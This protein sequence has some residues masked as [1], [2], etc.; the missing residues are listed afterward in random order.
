MKFKKN[1][2]SDKKSKIQTKKIEKKDNIIILPNI[3]Q[4]RL[5][6]SSKSLISERIN[7]V[8]YLKNTENSRIK[9]NSKIRIINIEKL[10][11]D[12]NDSEIKKSNL[13]S[14]KDQKSKSVNSLLTISQNNQSVSKKLVIPEKSGLIIKKN[15]DFKFLK[16]IKEETKKTYLYTLRNKNNPDLIRLIM[17]SRSQWKEVYP[18]LTTNYHLKWG[19]STRNMD[20]SILNKRKITNHMEYEHE[21]TNKKNLFINLIKYC[22]VKGINAF[23]YIPFTV[24][25]NYNHT[26]NIANLKKLCTSS[27]LY[28]F[29]NQSPP[30]E[31]Q[32]FFSLGNEKVDIYK[33][34]NQSNLIKFHNSFI[35]KENSYWI[36]KPKD[37]CGG[38]LLILIDNLNDIEKYLRKFY[39]GLSK[40]TDFLQSN[41]ENEVKSKEK[42]RFKYRSPVVLLQKYIERPLLY[43]KRKFDIR[44][45]VLVSHKLEVYVFKEGH[46]ST[47]LFEFSIESIS[48]NIHITNYDIQRKY[49]NFDLENN[50]EIDFHSFQKYL[51]SL[52][53][54]R[55]IQKPISI[56]NDLF[57]QM[58]N[59]I[60]TTFKSVQSIINKKNREY[61]FVILGY[62][63]LIDDDFKAWLLEINKNPGLS[64]TSN[65]TKRLV[66]RMIDDCIKITIDSIFKSENSDCGKSRFPIEPY[67]D[68]DNLWE[69]VEIMN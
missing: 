57:P 46:L 69:K 22:D 52:Y 61:S 7:I 28:E 36:L 68:Y 37:L 4:S 63:F 27:Q 58:K 2:S 24:I 38:K 39:D 42:N 50:N 9:K 23:D 6:N 13:I 53:K 1:F 40:H 16:S 56:R 51:D 8:S 48:K 67:S 12:T 49:D 20:F 15:T 59:T 55:T 32:D 66:P 35:L 33:Y 26:K 10:N 43:N 3:N 5:S 17:S 21:L 29:N 18:Y 41:D 14:L 44:I 19:A 64:F 30:F 60:S 62:D 34:V 25:L 31:Y 45:W 11:E 47:S 65:V 54:G